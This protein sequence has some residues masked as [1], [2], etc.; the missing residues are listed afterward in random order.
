ML[1]SRVSSCL[2]KEILGKIHAK[3]DGGNCMISSK[4]I[5]D[6]LGSRHPGRL[7]LVAK[8]VPERSQAAAAEALIDH[9]I[10][11]HDSAESQIRVAFSEYASKTENGIP[12]DVKGVEDLADEVY[13][14]ICNCTYPYLYISE[15]SIRRANLAAHAESDRHG[16]YSRVLSVRPYYAEFAEPSIM[17]TYL[18]GQVRALL[19]EGYDIEAGQ[20]I[21]P[22]PILYAVE[23]LEVKESI[24]DKRSAKL[25]RSV[26]PVPDITSVEDGIVDSNDEK[27]PGHLISPERYRH[28]SSYFWSR[29]FD[30]LSRDKFVESVPLLPGAKDPDWQEG[31]EPKHD[32]DGLSYHR[33]SLEL[34][35]QPLSRN[36]EPE[37]RAERFT[38]SRA[39]SSPLTLYTALRVD[40][41]LARLR[42]YTLTKPDDFQSHVLLTNYKKYM[43]QFIEYA[44]A[45]LLLLERESAPSDRQATL[46]VSWKKEDDDRRASEVEGKPN[47][48]DE[49]DEEGRVERGFV[50]TASDVRKMLDDPDAEESLLERLRREPTLSTNGGVNEFL[51]QKHAAVR[52][53][54]DTIERSL[55]DCQMPTLHF[56]PGREYMPEFNQHDSVQG[57][58]NRLVGEGRMPGVTIINIGVGPSNAKNIT[59]HLAVLRSRSWTMVGHCAGVRRR[60]ELGDFVI[61]D[62]CVRDDAVLDRQVPTNIPVRV[63]PVVAHALE[64]AAMQMTGGSSSTTST[65]KTALAAIEDGIEALKKTVRTGAV[66]TTGDRHWETWPAEEFRKIFNDG[67]VVGVDMESGTVAANA[68]RHR[69]H[70]GSLLCISDKPLHGAMKMRFF[71]DEFYKRQVKRHLRA[72]LNALLFLDVDPKSR[73]L[74]ENSREFASPNNPPFK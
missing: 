49:Q 53:L 29:Y 45:N 50:Y 48:S 55:A 64:R 58:F 8:N 7:L 6:E 43:R 23:R 59:D 11:L 12:D 24:K 21:N 72:A 65:S 22:I 62:A 46:T 54:L 66:F 20:S 42:H 5:A 33:T 9:L 2:T 30:E 36:G 26:F 15:G 35:G 19:A 60:Q 17:R 44:C 31:R 16:A 40:Y 13:R 70:S 63:S 57:Q 47:P 32:L 71:S 67:R 51:P 52:D 25:L 4:E 3:A 34:L 38:A 69:V 37:G 68:Y 41:S 1:P 74:L 10:L 73:I 28:F 14:N 18:V 61:A 27:N 56:D 39:V